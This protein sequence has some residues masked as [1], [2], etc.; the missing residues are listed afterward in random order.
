MF[1]ATTETDE[2]LR[3]RRGT[4]AAMGVLR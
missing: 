2:T 4:A 3:G 1:N